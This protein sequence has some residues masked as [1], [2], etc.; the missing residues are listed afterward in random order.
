MFWWWPLWQRLQENEPHKLS[1]KVAITAAKADVKGTNWSDHHSHEHKQKWCNTMQSPSQ[2]GSM[3]RI[4][5]TQGLLL[6]NRFELMDSLLKWP[7]PSKP[8]NKSMQKDWKSIENEGKL[9]EIV[10]TLLWMKLFLFLLLEFEDFSSA[11]Y[12]KSIQRSR[13]WARGSNVNAKKN[14]SIGIEL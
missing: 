4:I 14:S 6:S 13:Q 3:N 8:M 5:H 1:K 11:L 12:G 7:P 10:K 2:L 9:L